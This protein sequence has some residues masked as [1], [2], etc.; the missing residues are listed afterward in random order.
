A[1]KAYQNYQNGKNPA[2]SREAGNEENLLPPPEDNSFHPAQAPQGE[3]EFALAL[4]RAM[5][6]AARADGH[7]DDAERARIADRLKEAGI[8]EEAEAFLVA[9]LEKPVDLDALIASARTD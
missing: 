6:A 4:V 7:I 3:G 1:Y 8:D 2:E 9:E 5:I